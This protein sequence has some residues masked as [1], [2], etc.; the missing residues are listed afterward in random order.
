VPI[1]KAER[2]VWSPKVNPHPLLVFWTRLWVL[3][4][5]STG[6]FRCTAT[7][8]SPTVLVTA[9]HC[10]IGTLGKTLV[11][12]DSVIA[13]QPP[14]PFPVAADPSKGYTQA[15]LEVPATSPA[16]RTRTRRTRTSPTSTTGTTS[17]SSCSTDR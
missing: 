16:Q 6:R 1:D 5:D 8:V 7:L 11:T 17:A 14:S 12:F 9:A 15:E 3:L 13:E 10:T 4:Y 2:F